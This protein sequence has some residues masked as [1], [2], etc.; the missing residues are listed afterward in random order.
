MKKN[1]F[2]L[3]LLI[4][5]LFTVFFSA[6]AQIYVKIRP[7]FPIVVRTVQ[8][9]HQHVWIEEDWES[10]GGTYVYVGGHWVNPPLNRYVWKKGHWK[11]NRRG[12]IWI[13]GTWKRR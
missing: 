1:L 6:S 11:H 9:S 5:V 7:V 8:P 3:L 10:R 12:N 2:K 13:R 4:V